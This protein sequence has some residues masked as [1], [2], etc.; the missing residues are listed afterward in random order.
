[1]S[2]RFWPD[3]WE[4]APLQRVAN[5]WVAWEGRFLSNQ[6]KNYLFTLYRS[7]EM[8]SISFN[9]AIN[10]EPNQNTPQII[11]IHHF[12]LVLKLQIFWALFYRE[13]LA[14]FALREIPSPM[15]RY[16]SQVKTCRDFFN[17]V[18]TKCLRKKVFR[19]CKWSKSH[20]SLNML[21]NEVFLLCFCVK[22]NFFK[23]IAHAH[24]AKRFFYLNCPC[25]YKYLKCTTYTVCADE[26]WTY[27]YLHKTRV[28]Q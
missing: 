15:K 26:H 16:I 9:S 28:S 27:S 24:V 19:K 10:E 23:L 12:I 3:Q 18:L 5:Q 11:L 21:R 8:S 4:E 25:Y 20:I 13:M 17:Y 1:M 14:V 2:K 6:F 7:N 22:R